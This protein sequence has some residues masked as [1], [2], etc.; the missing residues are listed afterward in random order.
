MKKK[1]ALI[2]PEKTFTIGCYSW[3]H[4]YTQQILTKNRL[5]YETTVIVSKN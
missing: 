3:Y 4:W 2:N 5:I 1:V